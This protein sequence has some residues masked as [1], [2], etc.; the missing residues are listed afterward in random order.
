MISSSE[1]Y[2]SAWN[3]G[4]DSL[5]EKRVD[6][7]VDQLIDMSG[8]NISW[9]QDTNFSPHEA[10]YL[11]L[12]S[13]KAINVLGWRPKWSIGEAIK[14]TSIWYKKDNEGNDARN[15]SLEQIQI[16]SEQ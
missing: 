9:Q 7:I 8:K 10:H 6:W 13:T 3:F 14:N 12:D 16:Y 2:D 5:D 11:R 1:N 4:P 15:I